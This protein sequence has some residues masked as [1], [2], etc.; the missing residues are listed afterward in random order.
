MSNFLETLRVQRWDDHRYY[1]H[2]MIN[3]SLHFISALS[4]LIAYAVLFIAPP[5]AA[6]IAWLVS[7]TTRQSGHFFFEPKG[8]DVVNQATN[9]HKEEIKIGYNIQR[10]VVL[11]AIWAALP[12]LVY[13][14]PNFFGLLTPYTNLTEFALNVGWVW[15]FLG[16]AGLLFRVLHLFIIKDVETGLVWGFKIL[17]D[18]F[19][20]LML[21]RKSPWR[22]AHGE[23]IDQR[24]MSERHA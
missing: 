1:H 2:S 23:L 18:P 19:H 11:M 21:Y 9:E 7:M 6:L 10:K 13:L 8:Y 5:V 14:Q 4:F 12:L 22:L 17:T 16:I 15:L 20:D 24:S 3:Q